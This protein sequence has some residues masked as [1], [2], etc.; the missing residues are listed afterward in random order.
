MTGEKNMEVNARTSEGDCGT[1]SGLSD[2]KEQGNAALGSIVDSER[3]ETV[4]NIMERFDSR[5]ANAC[6]DSKESPVGPVQSEDTNMDKPSD[7]G[8]TTDVEV[9]MSTNA[10]LSQKNPTSASKFLVSSTDDL[11]EM[12][13]IGTVD[14]VEQEAQMKE[15]KQSNSQSLEGDNAQPP[16]ISNAG[17]VKQLC[18][19]FSD[20]YFEGFFILYEG[21]F[22]CQGRCGIFNL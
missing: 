1:S 9:Q 8:E 22:F 16:A 19:F 2:C 13:D 6:G 18:L 3:E 12:M 11:D 4:L 14:Q 10:D 20:L 17:K 15:E 21:V 5:K 7:D